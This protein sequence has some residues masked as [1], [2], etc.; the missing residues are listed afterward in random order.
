MK[1]IDAI[2]LTSLLVLFGLAM[3]LIIM[4][5]TDNIDS[6]DRTEEVEQSTIY[7]HDPYGHREQ[8]DIT[9]SDSD[10]SKSMLTH[11]FRQ[12]NKVSYGLWDYVTDDK[13]VQEVSEYL[14]GI[15]EGRNASQTANTA[16]KFVQSAIKYES[17]IEIYGQSEF[18]AYPLETLRNRAGDCEDVSILSV[19]ILTYMGYDCVFLDYPDH[20][21]VGVALD[22]P[23]GFH[24][25]YNGKNYYYAEAT[26][27]SSKIGSMSDLDLGKCEIVDDDSSPINGF[28][29]KVLTNYR[30]GWHNIANL[31]YH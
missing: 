31:I 15:C 17:D 14:L 25:E 3:T 2:F 16:L 19:S 18:R 10:Y 24:H 30:Y 8:F 21:A 11:G 20:I 23:N 4:I 28:I 26:S 13:Y 7:W 12:S 5:P 9:V 1:N 27:Y 6:L 29:G 22:S